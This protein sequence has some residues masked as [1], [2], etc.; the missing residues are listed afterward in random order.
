MA[1]KLVKSQTF[2]GMFGRTKDERRSFRDRAKAT[3][4]MMVGEVNPKT[5]VGFSCKELAAKLSRK[6]V[7][8]DDAAGEWKGL[9][10]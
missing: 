8:F 10:A 3:L 6:G 4:G 7:K 1:T 5:G 2:T 9:K